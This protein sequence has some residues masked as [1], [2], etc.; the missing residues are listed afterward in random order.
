MPVFGT[1][2]AVV[3]LGEQLYWYHVAGAIAIGSGIVLSLQKS[4]A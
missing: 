3:F 4:G 2:M 1:I